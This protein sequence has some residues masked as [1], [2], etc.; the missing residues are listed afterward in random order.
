[1]CNE[2]LEDIITTGKIS[3][4]RDRGRQKEMKLDDLRLWHG[5]ISCMELIQNTRDQEP[6]TPAPSGKAH[7]DDD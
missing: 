1:M 3:G 5:G 7:D 6:W 2:K 4:G